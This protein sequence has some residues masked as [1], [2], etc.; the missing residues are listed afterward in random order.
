VFGLRGRSQR[1]REKEERER[2]RLEEKEEPS[3]GTSATNNSFDIEAIPARPLQKSHSASSLRSTKLPR[4]LQKSRSATSL[5]S[6]RPLQKSRSA[7]SLKSSRR[8]GN[9]PRISE[10]VLQHHVSFDIANSTYS[11]YTPDSTVPQLVLRP[12]A[13]SREALSL[14]IFENSHANR[15]MSAESSM[16]PERLSSTADFISTESRASHISLEP[17]HEPDTSMAQ[18]FDFSQQ[19]HP[20]YTYYRGSSSPALNIQRAELPAGPVQP[21]RARHL[22]T[23]DFS[24]VDEDLTALPQ[25]GHFFKRYSQLNSRS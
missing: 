23:G 8:H 11:V 2:R 17:I 6:S 15:P 24:S 16:F 20:R 19:P 9:R 21:K 14:S 4:S 7:Q 10:P 13:G 5:N 22:S 1:K 25:K 3:P 18:A 12:S